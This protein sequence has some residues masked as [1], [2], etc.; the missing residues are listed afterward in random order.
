MPD[1]STL[2]VFGLASLA[3]VAIPGPNVIYIATR[4]LGQGRH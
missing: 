2:L 1:W 4:N 3:L